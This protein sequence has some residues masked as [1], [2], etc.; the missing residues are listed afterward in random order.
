[1]EMTFDYN[2]ISVANKARVK[3]RAKEFKARFTDGDIMWK[4]IEAFGR[5]RGLHGA[6]DIIKCSVVA[7]ENMPFEENSYSVFMILAG[8]KRLYKVHFYCNDDLDIEMRD[9]ILYGIETYELVEEN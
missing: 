2:Y 1:M 3:E 8:Y 6:E 7:A 9:T 5:R 4:V